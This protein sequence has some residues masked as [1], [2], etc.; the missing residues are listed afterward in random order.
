MRNLY[1]ALAKANGLEAKRRT[2]L[3]NEQGK[4]T[5]TPEEESARARKAIHLLLTLVAEQHPSIK[6][7]PAYKEALEWFETF[8]KIKVEVDT[9]LGIVKEV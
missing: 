7:L 4:K 5:I 8:E 9:D 2:D 1:N 6:E 3:I